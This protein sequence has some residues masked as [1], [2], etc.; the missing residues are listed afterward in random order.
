MTEHMFISQLFP[1]HRL[2][3]ESKLQEDLLQFI[4]YSWL[5]YEVLDCERVE[6]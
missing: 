6:M 4:K 5:C 1:V 3:H 2:K